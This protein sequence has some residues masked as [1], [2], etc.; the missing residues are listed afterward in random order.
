MAPRLLLIDA[1]NLIRRIHAAVQAPDD[2]SQVDGALSATIASTMRALK[3]CQPT[4]VLVVFDG[5]PPT[6]RHKL[7]PEYKSH[8]KPMPTELRNRLT[9]FNQLFRQN[10]IMTFRRNGIEADD[11]ISAITTKPYKQ[12]FQQRFFLPIKPTG[13]C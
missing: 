9:D 10:G 12:I 5:D 8:R 2:N 6:W 11:V 13:S 7:L 3:Q 4:H 1:L